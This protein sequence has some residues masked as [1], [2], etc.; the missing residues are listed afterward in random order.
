MSCCVYILSV[1]FLRN[2]SN[3]KQSKHILN[4]SNVLVLYAYT[5]IDLTHIE[6]LL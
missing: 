6:V 5:N 1:R 3:V 4:M 2:Y